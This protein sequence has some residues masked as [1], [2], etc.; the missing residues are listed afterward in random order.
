M[1]REKERQ[2]RA[3]EYYGGYC[4][5]YYVDKELTFNGNK[6]EY[7]FGVNKIS[8]NENGFLIHFIC[9][10]ENRAYISPRTMQH[11][12]RIVKKEIFKDFD[13][14]SFRHKHASMLAEFGVKQKYIQTR[15]SHTNINMTLNIYEHTTETMCSRGRKAINYL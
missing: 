1:L 7:P 14:H 4:T 8:A 6:P 10:R 12:S 2:D 5:N 11:V 15:L 3:K 9:I 13:Y